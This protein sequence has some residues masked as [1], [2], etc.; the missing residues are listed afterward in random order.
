MRLLSVIVAGF[1][2]GG[3]TIINY[4]DGLIYSDKDIKIKNKNRYLN[5]CDVCDGEQIVRYYITEC[6]IYGQCYKKYVDEDMVYKNPIDGKLY[7]YG[8]YN[9]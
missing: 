8:Y 3:C 1:L 9:Y 6:D 7:Y 5:S 2:F 4:E